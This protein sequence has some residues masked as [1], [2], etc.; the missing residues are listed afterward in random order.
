MKKNSETSPCLICQS[1]KNS[2]FLRVPNRF[3]LEETFSLVRCEEC[4]F[5]F[6]S[7]R[8][9]AQE[10][11][12]YYEDEDYQPH[13]QGV[14]SLSGKIYQWVRI[15]NNI[16]KR[17][18]IEKL[19]SKG[20]IL[21]YGCGTGEFLKEM[22]TA[23]WE[24]RGFEPSEKARETASSYGIQLIH[25]I[26]QLEKPVNIITLWHVL[27]HIHQPIALIQALK[28]CLDASGYLL[29]AVPNYQS[30][31]AKIFRENWVAYDAPRHLYHFQPADMERFL[32]QHGFEII[33]Y[34]RLYFDP[35][36]NALLSAGLQSRGNKLWFITL[37]TIKSLFA[38][39]FSFLLG[40][41]NIKKHASVI[42]IAKP[43]TQ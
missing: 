31:D 29:I 17:K 4:N 42:Y 16:Y 26:Q 27:E 12:A 35:W 21:D 9:D 10:I 40:R 37:G 24:V 1:Q 11:L 18:M 22:K 14:R 6:L 41:L 23:D 39:F 8:P 38:A 19:V 7:P 28:K 20:T 25:D 2:L 34:R 36:Y 30:F 15:R 32:T 13:Q 33:D 3:N 5:K 43:V